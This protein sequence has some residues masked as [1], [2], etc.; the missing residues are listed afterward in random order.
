MI[1]SPVFVYQARFPGRIDICT[2]NYNAGTYGCTVGIGS[3][4]AV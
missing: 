2:E 3:I 1:P 4:S